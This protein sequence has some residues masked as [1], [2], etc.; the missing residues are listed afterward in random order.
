VPI[1]TVVFI[2]IIILIFVIVWAIWVLISYFS[3]LP[4][5]TPLLSQLKE[6]GMAVLLSAMASVP[7][8]DVFHLDLHI[9]VQLPN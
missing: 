5:L 4:L 3:P 8:H 2:G 6:N 7:V 9:R 1:L